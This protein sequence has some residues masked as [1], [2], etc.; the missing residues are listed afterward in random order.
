MKVLLTCLL[1]VPLLLMGGCAAYTAIDAPKMKQRFPP[2]GEF[3]T[4]DGLQLHYLDS[5]PKN[6]PLVPL[7]MIHGASGNLQDLE[8]AL[9]PELAEN[10][11]VIIFDRPGFGYS[12]R[13][14]KPQ[15]G[16]FDPAQQAA[17]INS[18]LLKL[19]IPKAVIFGH[20]YGGSVALRYGLDFPEA[21]AGL[22]SMAGP[23]HHWDGGINTTYKIGKTPI[24]GPL[25]AWN[26][27]YPAGRILINNAAAG[28]FE[29]NKMPENYV[30]NSAASLAL[31]PHTFLANAN[32]V[33]RLNDFLYEQETRYGEL[34]MPVLLI[35]G[36]ADTTVGFYHH[37]PQLMEVIDP[38]VLLIPDVG[39]MP[40]YAEPEQV[41]NAIESFSARLD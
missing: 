19:G 36:E 16:W 14:K 17:V 40:H 8:H 9:L 4:V 2:I 7:V 21:T 15:G 33:A 31:R 12:E 29:P 27:F 25:F 1:I 11:R 32:D 10:R 35:W 30:H 38:E 5:G 39:H 37:A 24:I 6:S 20:S 26:V 18:A 22:I 23:S 13:T 28:V 41:I 3:V 34:K